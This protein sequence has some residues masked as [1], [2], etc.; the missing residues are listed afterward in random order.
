MKIEYT[1]TLLSS[2]KIMNILLDSVL[3]NK[4][5]KVEY[6]LASGSDPNFSDDN[7][8]SLLHWSCQ[9]CYIEMVKLLHKYGANFDIIDINGITPLF[10]SSGQGSIAIVET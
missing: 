1:E 10:N 9:E 7:G 4:R 2:S 6:L 3:K 8:F 5:N